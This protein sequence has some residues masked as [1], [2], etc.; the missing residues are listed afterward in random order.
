MTKFYRL[1]IVISHY[2]H[3]MCPTVRPICLYKHCFLSLDTSILVSK[4]YILWGWLT[5]YNQSSLRPS[6][7]KQSIHKIAHNTMNYLQRQVNRSRKKATQM[8]KK[9]ACVC[10]GGEGG[11]TFNNL[12]LNT[13]GFC[14]PSKLKHLNKI[15]CFKHVLVFW[16]FC[17]NHHYYSL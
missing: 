7:R 13:F 3:C 14:K 2:H 11:S 6:K 12:C 5:L 1:G 4:G 17:L 10:G 9:S 16:N 15:S 8:E